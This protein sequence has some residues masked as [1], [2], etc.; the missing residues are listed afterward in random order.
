[1]LNNNG[2][3]NLRVI[4]WGK[5]DEHAVILLVAA[6]LGGAGLGAGCHHTVLEIGGDRAAGLGI[7][8]HALFHSL[9]SGVMK[10]QGLD[11]L[12]IAHGKHL[13]IIIA[14]DGFQQMGL[15]ADASGDQRAD[16]VG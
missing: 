13:G 15:P 6:Q 4:V 2:H 14:L 3:H 8:I 11:R 5:A 9:Q 7:A 10:L 1:M 12:R 16:I